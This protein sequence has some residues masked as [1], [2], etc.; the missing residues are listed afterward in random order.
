MYYTILML[1]CNLLVLFVACMI[2]APYGVCVHLFCV[3]QFNCCY[4]Y[5]IV[6]VVVVIVVIV[7][8][9]HSSFILVQFYN[10]FICD[11]NWD[12][13]FCFAVL[14]AFLQCIN[15]IWLP[16]IK[17]KSVYV[18]FGSLS[19]TC[20]IHSGIARVWCASAV[21]ICT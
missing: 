14:F 20:T 5:F 2:S 10:I 17:W 1:H 6:F 8:R 21:I 15:R 13:L 4:Y 12:F 19:V 7:R 16:A 9:I 18:S 3:H 11:W